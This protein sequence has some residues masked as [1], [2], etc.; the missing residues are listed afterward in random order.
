MFLRSGTCS[1]SS[2]PNVGHAPLLTEP[3]AVRHYTRLSRQNYAIDL[4][5]DLRGES[6]G[7]LIDQIGEVLRALDEEPPPV[8]GSR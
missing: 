2:K 4:G 8:S 7:L 1:G 6:Y 5:V 3:E